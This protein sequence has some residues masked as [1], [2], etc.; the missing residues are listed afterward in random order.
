[1]VIEFVE[2]DPA[3]WMALI[4]L[5]FAVACMLGMALG[6]LGSKAQIKEIRQML[7]L[8]GP[9]QSDDAVAA[10]SSPTMVIVPLE[11]RTGPYDWQQEGL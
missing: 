5:G 6:M 11:P 9:E 1:M 4:M 2:T 10:S 3:Y 7:A 8:D